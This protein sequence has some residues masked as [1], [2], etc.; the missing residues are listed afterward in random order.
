MQRSI[1]G[2]CGN[3]GGD[4]GS[5]GTD[6]P[7]QDVA[8][9]VLQ[10]IAYLSG[11]PIEEVHAFHA[12]LLSRDYGYSSD[13]SAIF[14]G[15]TG[16]TQNHTEELFQHFMGGCYNNYYNPNSSEET[17]SGTMGLL[18]GNGMGH[19]VVV[20][21]HSCGVYTYYDPQNGFSGTINESDIHALISK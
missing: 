7:G 20:T 2:G 3:Y 15:S 12:S 9:C 8:D 18:N 5:Y 13:L 19:A 21:G 16:V 14:S 1:Y 4:S 17:I 10:A 6:Y 11:R